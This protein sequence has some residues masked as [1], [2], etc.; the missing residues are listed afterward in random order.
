MNL[1]LGNRSLDIF[2]QAFAED[3]IFLGLSDKI[4]CTIK[5]QRKS[6][7]L[8]LFIKVK[9]IFN[10][11]ITLSGFSFLGISFSLISFLKSIS[12]ILT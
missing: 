9:D 11:T 8:L 4:P 5:V 2:P 3:L 12:A 1:P 6:F 10:N 7:S